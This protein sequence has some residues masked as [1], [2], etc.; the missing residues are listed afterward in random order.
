MSR[1]PNW[2]RSEFEFV[3]CN[4][5]LPDA[6]LAAGLSQR[7]VGAVQ[8]IRQG[9]H[10]YHRGDHATTRLSGMMKSELETLKDVRRCAVCGVRFKAGSPGRP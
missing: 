6:E 2:T 5:H 7:T 10:C 8:V 9:I 4:D 3:L 1:A